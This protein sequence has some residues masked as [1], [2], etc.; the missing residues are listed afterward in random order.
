MI[1]YGQMLNQICQANAL[2]L[3]RIIPS[4]NSIFFN[5]SQTPGIEIL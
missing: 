5:I 1:L 3:L 4:S 2:L